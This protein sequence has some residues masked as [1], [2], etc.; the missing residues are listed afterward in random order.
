MALNPN[1][2]DSGSWP[3]SPTLGTGGFPASPTLED[4]GDP[5]WIDAYRRAGGNVRIVRSTEDARRA[6]QIVSTASRTVGMP[7]PSFLRRL[8][9]TVT[10]VAAVTDSGVGRDVAKIEGLLGPSTPSRPVVPIDDGA[11]V[12]ARRA[13][14]VVFADLQ[15]K[16]SAWLDIFCP[17]VNLCMDAAHDAIRRGDEESL[18]H[19]A[20]S[21]RRALVALADHVEPAGPE[22]RRDHTGAMRQV[23]REQF[24]NRLF[25]YLGLRTKSKAHRALTLAELELIEDQLTPL[26]DAVAKGLHADST[27]DDLEQLYTTTWSVIA[28]VVQCAETED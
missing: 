23:G 22:E 7:T 27:K 18:A 28:R 9:D 6:G 24:K 14:D 26:V 13:T 2:S 17:K 20:L 4:L 8:Q 12:P 5:A 15:A 21:L 19:G 25:I 16:T 10:K 1:I 11:S 3:S